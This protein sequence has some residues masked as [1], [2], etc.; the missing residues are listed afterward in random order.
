MLGALGRT[1]V[2]PECDVGFGGGDSREEACLWHL[3]NLDLTLRA[4]E[5]C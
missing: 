5:A 1:S 2:D 4:L 3:D